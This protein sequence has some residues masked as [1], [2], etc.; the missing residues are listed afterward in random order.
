MDNALT[1]EEWAEKESEISMGDGDDPPLRAYID[2]HGSLWIG[3][4]DTA[5]A[6]G[7]HGLAALCLHGQ[8]FGFWPELPKELRIAAEK[9]RVLT[10]SPE[11]WCDLEC[12]AD[13]I[14]ALL[15]PEE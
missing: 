13:R 2:E 10:N 8:T 15:P 12:A 4:T 5:Q 1:K 3:V 11:D 14:A 9:L 7:R 6:I